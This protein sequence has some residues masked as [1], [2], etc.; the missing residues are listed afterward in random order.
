MN[1]YAF[2]EKKFT[3]DENFV[4]CANCPICYLLTVELNQST[5]LPVFVLKIAISFK[6]HLR[7][8]CTCGFLIA[9]GEHAR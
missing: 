9:S 7:N 5:E 2:K 8:A 3:N 6:S 1:T 4:N